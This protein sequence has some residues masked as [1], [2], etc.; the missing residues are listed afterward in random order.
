M[1]QASEPLP[2]LRGWKLRWGLP[3][4]E[5]LL[6]HPDTADLSVPEARRLP[7]TALPLPHAVPNYIWPRPYAARSGGKMP[8]AAITEDW[9]C[10]ASRWYP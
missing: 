10:S 6:E 3:R 9:R 1:N 4:A 2:L 8:A 7:E 5:G